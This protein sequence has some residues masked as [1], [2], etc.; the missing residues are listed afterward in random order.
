M[1]HWRIDLKTANLPKFLA[2]WYSQLYK[3]FGLCCQRLCTIAILST[4]CPQEGALIL[5]AMLMQWK[6]NTTVPIA[7]EGAINSSRPI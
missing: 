7:S 5:L 3:F 1:K 4:L 2:I 6:R